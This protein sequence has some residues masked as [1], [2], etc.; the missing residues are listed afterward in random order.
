ME[1]IYD[2]SGIAGIKYNNATYFY[3][4]DAQ[5]NICALIDSNGNV[6][7]K[8]KYDAWGNHAVLYLNKVNDKEQ[9]SEAD[10]A[11][12]DE[13]YAKNKTLAE[14]NPFR[15]RGYCYDTETGL[16]FL[17]TRY[18]DPEVGRF[19]TIDDIS[20]IDPETINGLNL[21]AYCGNNPVMGYD[22]EGTW[23]WGSFWRTL[24]VLVVAALATAATVAI[25]IATVGTAA[26]VLIGAGVGFALGMGMS[27]VTQAVTTGSVDIGKMF[28]DGFVGAMS[29]AVAA[30][31]IGLL[32]SMAVGGVLGG[33]TSVGEDI[34]DGK[35]INPDK[36]WLSVGV[37]VI[38]GLISG[39]GANAKTLLSKSNYIK[40]VLKTAV[41][42]KK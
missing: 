36:F 38:G 4:K 13:N 19:I 20:Y 14:L 28:L 10:E 24:G 35:G 26:P 37:G 9:Y 2:Q 34:I 6:V 3:R 32:G 29:G 27:A 18:Y 16:Y 40:D 7:V 23:D 30:T 15:Y 1:F 42:P 12:F 25:C 33:A 8:Y 31:G 21:Y 11:A 39:S 17:K 41:S 22:P 5:G